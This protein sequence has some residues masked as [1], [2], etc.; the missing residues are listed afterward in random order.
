MKNGRTNNIIERGGE[1]DWEDEEDTRTDRKAG[2]QGYRDGKY[3]GTDGERERG[4]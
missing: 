2:R 1:R 4:R 3:N